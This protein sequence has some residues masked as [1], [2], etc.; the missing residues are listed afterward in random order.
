[1]G[2]PKALVSAVKSAFLFLS[3]DKKVITF[4]PME[5]CI[6]GMYVLRQASVVQAGT[7]KSMFNCRQG[8]GICNFISGRL[9]DDIVLNT[10]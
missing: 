1:V 5:S 2:V 3:P 7:G 8:S 6:A 10:T 4:V 9:L